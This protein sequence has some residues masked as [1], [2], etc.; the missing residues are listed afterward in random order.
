MNIP[1]AKVRKRQSTLAVAVLSLGAL[2]AACS[3]S[4]D[5]SSVPDATS[6]P[7]SASPTATVP[8]AP[9]PEP[10]ATPVVLTES[11]QRA[12]RLMFEL[13]V[14]SYENDAGGVQLPA[15][16]QALELRHPGLIPPLVEI[17]RFAFEDDQ[18]SAL[19]DTLNKLT[20]QSFDG[21]DF[22][23]WHEWLGSGQDTTLLPGYANWKANLYAPFDTSFHSFL[24]NGVPTTIPLEGIQWGG[25]ARDG[26]PPLENP[27]VIPG[28]RAAFLDLEE[29]VFGVVINGEARAYPFRIMNSHEMANDVLGGVNVT[30]SY[31]TLCGSGILYEGKINGQV[32]TFGTSGFLYQSNKLMYDRTTNTLWQQQTGKPVVGELVGSGIQLEQIPM[33]VTRWGAWIEEHP[34]TTVLDLEQG[35]RRTYYHPDDARAIYFE[36]FNGDELL[37]PVWDQDTTLDAKTR[38]LGIRSGETA[39]AY[40]AEQVIRTGVVND[41]LAGV[42]L[43]IIGDENSQAVRAYQRG[44]N[45]FTASGTLGEVIDQDGEVWRVTED[46]LQPVRASLDALPRQTHRMSS[47]LAGPAS[48]PKPN[49]G[50]QLATEPEPRC[51]QIPFAT[52]EQSGVYANE[53]GIFLWRSRHPGRRTS[54]SR[55]GSG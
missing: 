51:S 1:R 40:I 27:K 9:T 13:F 3:S 25:V 4:G 5:V 49:S 44:E 35:F 20:G 28:N 7:G 8:P 22:F 47:G 31:C 17:T 48:S 32:E 37:F 46:A 11:D 2:A 42:P 12:A 30:L 45:T 19:G 52:L 21:D 29:I 16:E 24:Y 54:H 50:C 53:D 33:T 39:R 23:S 55:A 38:V 43:V 6:T 10:T 18:I 26:I 34:E 14:D 41:E 36:Y 15:L